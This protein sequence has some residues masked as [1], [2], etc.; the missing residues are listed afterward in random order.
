MNFLLKIVQGPNS[1][2]EIALIDGVN[3]TF[4]CGDDCDIILSD[5]SVGEKAFELEVTSERVVAVMPGGRTVKFEPYHV[6]LVGTTA[7]VVGPQE[8]EWKSLVWPKTEAQSEKKDTADVEREEENVPSVKRRFPFG[9]VAVIFFLLVIAA[10]AVFAWRK[11]PDQ[12]KNYSLK[13]YSKA[14][15]VWSAALEKFK[16]EQEEKA[17]VLNEALDDVAKDCAFTVVRN[18]E[19][20]SAKG[21]FLT[22]VKRLEATARACAAHPG[23]KIDFSDIESLSSAVREFL[24][25]VTEDKLKLDRI[26]GRKAFISGRVTSRESLE[27]IL[28]ALSEDV[29]K[30]SEVD[31]SRVQLG[32]VVG[33]CS[34]DHDDDDK[35]A[36]I[37]KRNTN[38]ERKSK[39]KMP[40][41]GILTVPYPC[42][43]LNDGTRAME[44]AR[45]GEYTIEKIAPDCIT[46]RGAEGS[47][48]WRP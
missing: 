21:D 28:R 13:A 47:F 8:G 36:P 23:L 7:L 37:A 9:C 38:Q 26:E 48:E 11:Y 18:G 33:A 19:E 43:V 15:E 45:F 41:A 39:P 6:I 30:I 29:S 27:K 2:A 46:V 25:L 17:I 20:V 5:T 24:F 44:G 31:T 14:K 10:L 35:A 40:I 4:G 32:M 16:S 42:L 12:T 1:G 3:L 34:L 22:R